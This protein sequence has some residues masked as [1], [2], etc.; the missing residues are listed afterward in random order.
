MMKNHHWVTCFIIGDNIRWSQ[1]NNTPFDQLTLSCSVTLLPFPSRNRATST[2]PLCA[3]LK[4]GVVPDCTLS[5]GDTMESDETDI[6]ISSVLYLVVYVHV[7]TRLQTR[8]TTTVTLLI[9]KTK[10]FTQLNKGQRPL[11]PCSRCVQR[12]HKMHQTSSKQCMP[13]ML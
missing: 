5:E 1:E 9:H 3:A 12:G 6:S 11:C 7:Q 13:M 8:V 10:K 4:S 2:W